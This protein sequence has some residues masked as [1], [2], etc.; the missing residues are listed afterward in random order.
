MA[1]EYCINCTKNTFDDSDHSHSWSCSD[2]ESPTIDMLRPDYDYVQNGTC[3]GSGCAGYV[4][5]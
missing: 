5:V 3:T 2:A 1:N 4:S